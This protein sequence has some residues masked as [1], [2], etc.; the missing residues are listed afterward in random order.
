MANPSQYCDPGSTDSQA[1]ANSISIFPASKQVANNQEL[2]AVSPAFDLV[3][4]IQHCS[5]ATP[6]FSIMATR[7]TTVAAD[8]TMLHQI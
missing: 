6:A 5:R 1:A 8:S 4:S 3:F 2:F 7:F